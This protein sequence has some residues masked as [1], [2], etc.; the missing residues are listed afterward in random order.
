MFQNSTYPIRWIISVVMYVRSLKAEIFPVSF[1]YFQCQ[2]GTEHIVGA[3]YIFIE[4][5]QKFSLICILFRLFA[6]FQLQE[7][8]LVAFSGKNKLVMQA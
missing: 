8:V 1:I 3:Q 2:K 6:Y 4:Y 7:R 5:M